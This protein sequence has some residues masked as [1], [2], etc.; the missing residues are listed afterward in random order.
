MYVGEKLYQLLEELFPILRS[1]TGNG[2]RQTLKIL[3]EHV[4][5][6]IHEVPSG[7]KVFDW[8]VPEEW[9]ISEA[10]IKDEERT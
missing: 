9:N 1:I 4:P 3:Q 5:I 8:T 7:T 2:V 6:E 10:Y